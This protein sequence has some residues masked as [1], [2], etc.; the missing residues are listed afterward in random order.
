MNEK[1]P[2]L[3]GEV[4][5]RL[6]TRY[7]KRLREAG[8]LPVVVYGHGKDTVSISVD[9]KETL[10]YIHDGKRV[11]TIDVNGEQ[12]TVLLRDVQFDYLGDGIIHADL[13]RVNLDETTH[14]NVRIAIK[15]DAVGLK[16]ANT[17]LLHPITELS[18]ECKLRDLPGEIV[19]NITDLEVEGII[20]AGDIDM[21]AGV[22]LLSDKHDILAQIAHSA[23]GDEE[24]T[25]E[26]AQVGADA[27]P[28]VISEK[29]DDEGE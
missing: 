26:G 15:G 5:E 23:G 19:V 16:E 2:V 7:S 24:A 6:G 1:A 12:E 13:S 4:R 29:K 14:A 22:T 11:F 17:L 8:R 25:G 9:T 20:H 28:A 18:I 10:R 3:K 21:P 27:Q